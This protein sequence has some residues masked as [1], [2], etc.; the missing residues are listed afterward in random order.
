MLLTPKEAAIYLR[1]HLTT[2]YRLC[3]AGKLP[4]LRV[5]GVYRIDSEKLHAWMA[6]P[7]SKKPS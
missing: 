6:G 1:V 3:K 7:E 4:H 5:G 2:I